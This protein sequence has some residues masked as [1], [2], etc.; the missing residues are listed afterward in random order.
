MIVTGCYPGV[1]PWSEALLQTSPGRMHWVV[2]STFADINGTA[3]IDI[4]PRLREPPTEIVET[5]NQSV[6]MRLTSGEALSS[7]TTAP[8]KATYQLTFEEAVP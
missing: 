5:T 7:P 2:G 3:T 1:S 4:V 6:L 8:A